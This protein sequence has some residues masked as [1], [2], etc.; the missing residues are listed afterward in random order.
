MFWNKI[1]FM[2]TD[3]SLLSLELAHFIYFLDNLM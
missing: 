3:V 1:Q 2:L